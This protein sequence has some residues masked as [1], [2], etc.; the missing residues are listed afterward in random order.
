VDV[1]GY[2][3]GFGLATAAGLNAWFPLLAVGLIA[4]HTG[5]V[6]L[7]GQWHMLEETPVL[8]A[9]GAVAVLDF[10]GDKVATVDH[11]LH[12]VGTVIAP[13]TGALS[14]V[15]ATDTLNVSPVAMTIVSIAAA[16]TTH[17]TR[18]AVRPFVTVGTVGA[19]NP[20]VSFVEDAISATLAILAILAPI[21][22]TLLIVLL[23]WIVWRLLRRLRRRVR[24][25]RGGGPEPPPAPA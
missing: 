3:T 7:D 17:G 2:L 8:I 4:R 10:I 23:A 11:V 12:M 24:Q 15:G 22:A 19:G 21:V 9:L 5:L 18:M 1:V 13:V 20:V 14:A 16:E 6:D 25:R